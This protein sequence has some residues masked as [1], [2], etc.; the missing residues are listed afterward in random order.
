MRRSSLIAAA[1]LVGAPAL[2]T[3]CGGSVGTITVGEPAGVQAPARRGD[4]AHLFDDDGDPDFT[5][6]PVSPAPSYDPLT[7]GAFN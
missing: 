3:G 2:L 5:D 7:A 1:L 6:A 4:S